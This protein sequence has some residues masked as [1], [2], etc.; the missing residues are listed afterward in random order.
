MR[1]RDYLIGRGMTPIN[2]KSH[3]FGVKKWIIAN[4]MSLD[5]QLIGRPKVAS[6]IKDRIPTPE[7]LRRILS[8]DV[9]LRDRAL[10]ITCAV[11]GLRVGT[12]TRIKVKDLQELEASFGLIKVEGG[13]GK[14]L[15]EGKCLRFCRRATTSEILRL[16]S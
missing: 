15:S 9:S 12:A 10:F 14:K 3:F 2:L 16:V 5:W 6:H 4:R 7:E 1:A 8:N 13:E 11:S